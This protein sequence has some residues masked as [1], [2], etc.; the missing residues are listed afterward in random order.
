MNIAFDINHNFTFDI[1]DWKSIVSGEPVQVKKKNKVACTVKLPGS[2]LVICNIL[3]NWS[4]EQG[5]MTRRMALLRFTKPVPTDKTDTNLLNKIIND[6]LPFLLVKCNLAYHEKRRQVGD[7]DV[8]CHWSYYFD[9]SMQDI[10]NE[11]NAFEAFL[12]SEQIVT[13]SKTEDCQIYKNTYI[14]DT[15]L[16]AAFHAFCRKQ[17]LGHIPWNSEEVEPK[18]VSGKLPSI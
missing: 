18:L 16:K 6:E 1:C 15:K 10:D 11:C 17:K 4:D 14:P 13:P 7:E 2:W 9:K 3:P 5:S 12:K 8:R